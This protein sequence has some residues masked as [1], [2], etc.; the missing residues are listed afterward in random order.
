MAMAVAPL[1]L[2]AACDNGERGDPQN[3]T[4]VGGPGMPG[5]GSGPNT[6]GAGGAG[7]AMG[8]GGADGG[9]G[10]GNAGP[11]DLSGSCDNCTACTQT[12][13]CADQLVDCAN[14]FNCV[15]ALDCLESCDQNSVDDT[16]YNQCVGQLCVGTPGYPQ[17][18]TYVQCFCHLGCANDCA[19]E[20]GRDC[21]QFLL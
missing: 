2:V 1:P 13:T 14:D 19:V 20:S 17:A 4:Q 16:S 15:A 11:C 7:A 18:Q 8:A 6:S 9:G 21:V 10:V 5:S 3:S 12:G